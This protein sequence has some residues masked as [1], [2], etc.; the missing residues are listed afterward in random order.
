MTVPSVPL[1]EAPKP[2]TRH[3]PP[4]TCPATVVVSPDGPARAEVTALGKVEIPLSGVV[5]RAMPPGCTTCWRLPP[6]GSHHTVSPD[7][8]MLPVAFER[9]GDGQRRRVLDPLLRKLV[10]LPHQVAAQHRGADAAD[11]DQRDDHQGGSDAISLIRSEVRLDSRR[12]RPPGPCRPA[13]VLALCSR[14]HA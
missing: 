12:S 4:G 8:S 6:S 10:R 11:R 9:A 7:C 13:A 5:P 2:K 3:R 14:R 1:T